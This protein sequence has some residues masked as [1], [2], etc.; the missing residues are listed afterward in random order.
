M[1]G[2][3]VYGDYNAPT[4]FY[5]ELTPTNNGDYELSTGMHHREQ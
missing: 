2:V 4:A 5:Y 3:R 1:Q